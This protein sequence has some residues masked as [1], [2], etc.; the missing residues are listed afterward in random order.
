MPIRV[1]HRAV[2]PKDSTPTAKEENRIT[3][4]RFLAQKRAVELA[5]PLGGGQIKSLSIPKPAL[6]PGGGWSLDMTFHVWVHISP[7]WYPRSAPFILSALVVPE[8]GYF[9]GIPFRLMCAAEL[10]IH[11]QCD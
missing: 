9:P 10:K 5:V 7:C 1:D 4:N 6:L 11:S 2:R 8:S 3:G